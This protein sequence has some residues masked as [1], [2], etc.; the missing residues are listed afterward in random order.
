MGET[1][2]QAYREAVRAHAASY[3]QLLPVYW[4]TF[5]NHRELAKFRI[6]EPLLKTS[7]DGPVTTAD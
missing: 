2:Y 5:D 4:A 7:A 3:P 6:L 1:A